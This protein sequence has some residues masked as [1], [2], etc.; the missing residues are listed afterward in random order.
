M[1]TRQ[2][3]IGIFCCAAA[4]LSWGGMFPVMTDVMRTMDP[5]MFSALRYG[6]AGIALVAVLVYREGRA[7]LSLAGERWVLAW[8]LGSA[9]FAG[10]GFLV[11]LGQKL[12][13]S[14][15][16]LTASIMMATMPMLGLLVIWGL[17]RIR[18]SLM[19]FV[20]I[21]LSFVGVILVVTNGH[22]HGALNESGGWKANALL[23]LG[24]LCWVVYTVGAGFFPTWSPYRYT[25]LTT[26]LGLTTLF[27]VDGIL[28]AMGA[29]SLPTLAATLAI[30][31]HLLYT[32]LIAGL[33]GVLCWNIGN[34]ILTPLNGVLFMNVVPLT[35]FMVSMWLGVIPEGAQMAGAGLTILSLVLNNLYQRRSQKRVGARKG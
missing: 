31:P 15:G 14:R 32:A 28:M 23:L 13:G 33:M 26:V 7:A 12:A 18:P 25:T 17:R 3:L 34:N 5:F 29:L 35:A 27:A 4:T 19:S 2:Y 30:T 24:A 21:V 22:L 10:F 1:Q 20:F 8:A 9:G 16:A 11:F 6:I